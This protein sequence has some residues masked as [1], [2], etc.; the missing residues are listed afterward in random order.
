MRNAT[1]ST[2]PTIA[3]VRAPFAD[4]TCALVVSDT[5]GVRNLETGCACPGL[6]RATTKH[7]VC[8]A[9]VP[10]RWLEARFATVRARIAEG[11]TACGGAV[12]MLYCAALLAG[13]WPTFASP[14]KFVA[15][16]AL[17]W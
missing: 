1:R 3:C 17:L 8:S 13:H 14:I 9:G 11:A 4:Y 5:V 7:A 6:A 12:S 16:L 15:L 2:I 10:T